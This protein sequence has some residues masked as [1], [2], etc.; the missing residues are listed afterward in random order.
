MTPEE[1]DKLLQDYLDARLPEA[2]RSAFEER[3]AGDP[4]LAR[5][6]ESYR[7]IGRELRESPADLPPGFY[8][9]ARDRFEARHRKRRGWFAPL[10]WETLGVAS[11]AVLLA[12]LFLPA[13]LDKP[14]FDFFRGAEPAQREAPATAAADRSESSREK[15]SSL[16]PA[17]VGA[18]V[19]EGEPSAERFD[20]A[21]T[22]E[23]NQEALDQRESLG[24]VGGED[25]RKKL[26]KSEVVRDLPAEP[27]RAPAGSR[28]ARAGRLTGAASETTP[29]PGKAKAAEAPP[30]SASVTVAEAAAPAPEESWKKAPTPPP[31]HGVVGNKD[32]LV[33]VE[34]RE[35]P[36]DRA[37]LWAEGARKA[38][39]ED[40]NEITRQMELESLR[41]RQ[42]DQKYRVQ[43][44]GQQRLAEG[45][46]ADANAAG[47]APELERKAGLPAQ[48][49]LA[50]RGSYRANVPE[51]LANA[52]LTAALPAGLVEPN[53]V[54][55][56]DR[57]DEW[58]G[59]VAVHRSGFADAD[60][61]GGALQVMSAIAVLEP[62]FLTQRVVLIG[63]RSRPI[64]CFRVDVV[65]DHRVRL[66]VRAAGDRP[67]AGEAGSSTTGC[68]ILI[69]A[70][71][72]PVEVVE[73]W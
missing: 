39:P 35:D 37:E 30:P 43:E 27:Q 25:N 61:A 70:G 44:E 67:E 36:A 41:R 10:S 9:R 50:A 3:L 57:A 63:P 62:D 51:S 56:V 14:P 49:E 32:D 31:E 15:E 2:E 73:L 7:R 53:A 54:R 66:L 33:V 42:E 5:R 60:Q 6:V 29:S 55:V 21:T 26:R 28:D 12:V 69:P 4:D 71:T 58:N 47:P 19:P 11:A 65:V 1:L 24:F 52:S 46:A 17:P 18:L 13:A 64:D 23:S 45:D 8:A 72:D 16:K 68:A 34:E 22:K 40:E 59:I 48:D 38:A 20:F